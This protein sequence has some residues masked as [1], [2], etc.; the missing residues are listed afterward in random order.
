MSSAIARL[1]ICPLIGEEN[2]LFILYKMSIEGPLLNLESEII[3]YTVG[4]LPV[5]SSKKAFDSRT[6]CL[7]TFSNPL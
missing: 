6:H 3:H 1:W 2:Y 7:N 4:L 5:T